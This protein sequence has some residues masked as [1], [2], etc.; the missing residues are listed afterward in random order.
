[1][2]EV[3]VHSIHNGDLLIQ[4]HIGIV[5]HAAGHPVLPLKQV[6]LMIVNTYI[7]NIVCDEHN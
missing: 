5:G 2:G 7:A 4:D 1:M 3:L 6:H